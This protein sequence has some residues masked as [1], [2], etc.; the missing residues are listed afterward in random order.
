[1]QGVQSRMMGTVTALD[2]PV[3]GEI[4]QHFSGLDELR[5]EI[6]LHIPA[7]FIRKLGIHVRSC[8]RFPQL[9]EGGLVFLDELLHLFW[10]G[11]EAGNPLEGRKLVHIG[12]GHLP[13]SLKGGAIEIPRVA[14]GRR[15][16]KK[17]SHW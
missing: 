10:I 1:M 8:E 4:L 2:M 17:F 6:K 7:H 9:P 15:L 14:V 12:R 5:V 13:E 16:E 11:F 3:E